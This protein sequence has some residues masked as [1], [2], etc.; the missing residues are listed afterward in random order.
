MAA[1]FGGYDR[2]FLKGFCPATFLWSVQVGRAG[3][4]TS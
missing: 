2:N 3:D 1:A 4:I